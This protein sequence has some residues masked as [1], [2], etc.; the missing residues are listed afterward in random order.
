MI[1]GRFG[2]RSI[3]LASLA[4]AA[5]A[6]PGAA[7]AQQRVSP[8]EAYDI[9]R[10]AYIYFYPLVSMDATRVQTNAL[11]GDA[12]NSL[13]N[14]F[15]HVRSFPA[16][17]FKMV[18][19]SNFDT[20]Y[21][22]AWLDLSKEPMIVSAPDTG[23][24]YY[25]LPMLDMWSD[26]FAAPGKRTSGT[27]AAHFVVVPPG[28]SGTLPEDVVRIDAPTPSVWI[29]GRTQTNGPQDYAAVH[30]IQDG[31]TVTPLSR[32]GRAVPPAQPI[33]MPAGI[34]APAPR[35]LVDRMP[36]LDYFKRAAELMKANPPH[37]TDW[38]IIARLERIGI[39]V[40]QSYDPE[41]LDPAIRD[42]L[43]RA[44]AD[45]QKAMR[46]KAPTLARIVNGWQMNTDTM[47]VYGNNYLKRAVVA[48]VLLGAN[49]P[50]EAV[51]PLIVTDA[52]GK[53][54]TGDNAYVLHFEKADLPPV[55]AFWSLSMYDADGFQVA[56]PINRFAVGDRDSL[57]Y[58]ADGSLDLYI[59]HD[60]PGGDRSANWLP[61]PSLGRLGLTMRLYAPKAEV[62]AGDWAPPP[63]RRQP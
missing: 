14:T 59:Q 51:Y 61:S 54:P 30:R 2:S 10:E 20:L 63:L 47:G 52:D 32:W 55:G 29:V 23:G 37:T 9:A 21:S 62:L 50:E 22:T 3:I 39:V 4:L 5:I 24:R 15:V 36:A 6:S 7:L 60:N 42:A 8:Q 48:Q 34:K 31:Y 40:G 18:V 58:N 46:A 33:S 1:F 35:D 25:T 45:G 57:T 19:R 38:S 56:N 26:V 28:W 44:V 49:P 11:P 41:R 16:A 17:D 43:T 12:P 13:A 53:I 27:A